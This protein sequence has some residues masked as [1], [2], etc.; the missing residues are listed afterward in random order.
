M[1]ITF[2]KSAHFLLK[3]FSIFRPLRVIFWGK[4]FKKISDD[5]YLQQLCSLP[6]FDWTN[7]KN[8]KCQFAEKTVENYQIFHP[9]L[10]L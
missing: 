2:Q 3:V 5:F 9:P 1:E 6:F 4:S 8:K 7:Q 10:V